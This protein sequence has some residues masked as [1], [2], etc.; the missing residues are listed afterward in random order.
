MPDSALL[1][2]VNTLFVEE[3]WFVVDS[4]LLTP[5][6]ELVRRASCGVSPV[7]V[8][9]PS[10][11]LLVVVADDRTPVAVVLLPSSLP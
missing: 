7:R 4:A 2:S 1:L 9:I 6:L 11:A 8:L 3:R 10:C 5:E